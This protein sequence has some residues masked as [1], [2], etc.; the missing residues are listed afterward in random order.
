MRKQAALNEENN[1]INYQRDRG[2]DNQDEDNSFRMAASLGHI[3]HTANSTSFA[4]FDDGFRKHDVAK[5]QAEEQSQRIE[6]SRHRQWEQHLQ[7]DLPAL[8]TKCVRRIDVA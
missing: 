6:N 2:N 1:S 7:D 8:C 3:D 5:R 4:G